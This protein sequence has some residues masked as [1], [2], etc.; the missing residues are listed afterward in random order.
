M[1][2]KTIRLGESCDVKDHT[3]CDLKVSISLATDSAKKYGL[4]SYAA[5]KTIQERGT[6]TPAEAKRVL[7]AWDK[8]LQAS[9]APSHQKTWGSVILDRL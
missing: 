5:L 4:P 3:P 8:Q 1:A 2:K 9:K 6:V 7:T